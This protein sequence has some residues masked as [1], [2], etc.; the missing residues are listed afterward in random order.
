M[1]NNHQNFV[2]VV[3]EDILKKLQIIM[4]DLTSNTERSIIILKIN[5][6]M[7][8][9]KNT[10]NNSTFQDRIINNN[11]KNFK[12]NFNYGEYI[13]EIKNGVPN[14]RGKLYY[15]GQYNGDIYE[16]DFKNGEPEGRGIYYHHN[17][18]IYDGDFKKDRAD[19]K[20]IFYCQDGSRYEGDFIKDM[21]HGKGVFYFQNGDRMMGDYF[22]NKEIG[23]HVILHAN[24]QI[25]QKN[26]H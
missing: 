13:G 21:R 25:S 7:K 8:N 10:I 26:F 17:G 15:K 1:D 5:E 6:L 24:G 2:N 14:G 16:G 9:I 19:G 18:N 23:K 4:N 11:T 12:I 3:F 20:G 22:N